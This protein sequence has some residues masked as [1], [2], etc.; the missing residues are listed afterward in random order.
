MI[1]LRGGDMPQTRRVQKTL[2]PCRH[3]SA[4]KTEMY[5]NIDV[6]GVTAMKQFEVVEGH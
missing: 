3:S 4:A 2:V 6:Q 1:Y 5:L